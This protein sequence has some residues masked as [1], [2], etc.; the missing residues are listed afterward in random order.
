MISLKVASPIASSKP[1]A[2]APSGAETLRR[3]R[4]RVKPIGRK[5]ALKPKLVLASASPRRLEL[6][7]QVG[8]TPDALRPASI[9]ETPEKRER[10]RSYASR[11]AR[12]KAEATRDAVANDEAL[13]DAFILAADTVVSCEGRI[14]IKPQTVDEALASLRLLSGRVHKV[15]TAIHL[16]TPDD[17]ARRQLVTT[18]VRFKRLS[19]QE[20]DSY[21]ASREWRDKA[22][23]YAIQGLAAAFVE[24]IVGSY[25]GVVGL[26]LSEIVT[27]LT[28]EGLPVH[29]NWLRHSDT[30]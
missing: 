1:A 11:V 4:A 26:P 25:T 29:Y 19:A 23:G 18:K 7:A 2:P 16:L 30:E 24:K 17:T 3:A 14:L 15:Y 12:E 8:V 10:A 28:A 21:V 27:M 9:D 22:G 20:I 6:L 5:A 13:A